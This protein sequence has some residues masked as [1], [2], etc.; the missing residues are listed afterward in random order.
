VSEFLPYPGRVLRI[1]SENSFPIT[2]QS[3]A[4]GWLWWRCA[5]ESSSRRSRAFILQGDIIS[6]SF[7][8]NMSLD[9]CK[10]RSAVQSVIISE[11]GHSVNSNVFHNVEYI[12]HPI[13]SHETSYFSTLLTS[14]TNAAPPSLPLFSSCIICLAPCS[15]SS[16]K[17][18]LTG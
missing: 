1:S 10:V 4:H 2:V 17:L 7:L 13:I 16:F 3:I 5:T 6:T 15:T 8:S 12:S 11:K 18:T 9:G 14:S